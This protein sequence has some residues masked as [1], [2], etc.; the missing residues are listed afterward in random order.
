MP[1][2]NFEQKAKQLLEEVNIRP[3]EKV[4]LE[5]EK[6]I[7]EKKRRRWIIIFP[8]LAALGI[9]GYFIAENFIDG[10]AKR[11]AV[12]INKTV[13]SE[14]EK[15]DRTVSESDTKLKSDVTAAE[16]E[17]VKT[18]DDGETVN[19]GINDLKKEPLAVVVNKKPEVM[20]IK[21]D[22]PFI[23]ANNTGIKKG[24]PLPDIFNK[25]EAT[26]EDK[27]MV[28]EEKQRA[29][30]ENALTTNET[31]VKETV[32]E[33]KT[34]TAEKTTEP[35]KNDEQKSKIDKGGDSAAA[36]FK[37]GIKKQKQTKSKWQ[38][39]VAF[40]G[41]VSNIKSKV[42]GLDLGME[43]AMLD[44]I[45]SSPLGGPQT[46]LNYPSANYQAFAVQ[47]GVFAQKNISKRSSVSVGI[48]YALYQTR[49]TVGGRIDSAAVRASNSNLYA[50]V[51][52]GNA[53]NRSNSNYHSRLHYIEVPVLFST[54]LTN[55]KKLPLQWNGGISMAQLIGSNYLHYDTAN[56]GIYFKDNRLLAKT[57]ISLQ[58]G[59]AL[60]LF[61][62]SKTPV[63]IGPHI[64][65]G[66]SDLLKENADKR[67]LLY[68][69]MRLQ[70]LINQKKKK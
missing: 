70:L 44:V 64:Q 37:P 1:A 56:R 47:T 40:S 38:L 8:L 30:P 4:W 29:A 16:N 34:V 51:W 10:T 61:S 2:N 11:P 26:V 27:K 15:Q 28:Q 33:N 53:A 42:F 5:V 14:T 43:K 19:D 21:K 22:K 9:A 41:G 57:N 36:Q 50:N 58:T 55:N 60:T 46:P 69:G 7:R 17:K 39:G 24:N 13:D 68:S 62:Q 31:T 65:F 6:R 20:A 32:T 63:T 18:G 45:T 59:F 25:K 67:Y 12:T 3:N 35:V 54:Q 48:N 66:L 23:A 49:I 52:T